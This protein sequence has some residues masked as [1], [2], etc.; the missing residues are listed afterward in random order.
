MR[1]PAP[2]ESTAATTGPAPS[3]RERATVV[4]GWVPGTVL[5]L[6]MA[7][8]ACLVYSWAAR[9]STPSAV[10]A[11]ATTTALVH[12]TVMVAIAAIIAI[13]YVSVGL[14]HRT[15][16]LRSLLLSYTAPLL[17]VLGVVSIV[18]LA[19]GSTGDAFR[20]AVEWQHAVGTTL[21]ARSAQTAWWSAALSLLALAALIPFGYRPIATTEFDPPPGRRPVLV[22]VVITLVLATAITTLTAL[23]TRP[24]EP[25]YP[26]SGEA[27]TTTE[28]PSTPAGLPT[29]EAFRIPFD[30]TD[31]ATA[32][33]VNL[34]ILAGAGIVTASTTYDG[35]AITGI[36]GRTGRNLWTLSGKGL[37]TESMY[38]T[39]VGTKSVVAVALTS[40]GSTENTLVGIDATTGTVLWS[41]PR[42]RL[43]KSYTVNQSRGALVV[44]VANP[45]PPGSVTS[46][47]L[48][49]RWI[50]LDPRTGKELWHRDFG[51]KCY[52]QG[53]VSDDAV[54]VA[55]CG[56]PRNGL[57]GTLL[58]VTSGREVRRLTATDLG[59]PPDQVASVVDVRGQYAVLEVGDDTVVANVVSGRVVKQFRGSGQLIDDHSVRIVS[60]RDDRISLADLAT[61]KQVTTRI[62]A[63]RD[64]SF[65][66]GGRWASVDGGWVGPGSAVA[67]TGDLGGDYAAAGNG[68]KGPD[69]RKTFSV[70]TSGQEVE[71]PVGCPPRTGLPSIYRIP[72]SAL[73]ICG[74]S[75]A[76]GLI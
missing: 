11:E 47:T 31:I 70:S 22:C 1:S 72:G 40:T 9:P 49:T 57:V 35:V 14:R 45:E 2:A 8:V 43:V 5:G 37:G 41:I 18:V 64:T 55:P 21:V 6:I 66:S 74:N 63:L 42:I 76:I 16:R 34:Q 17:A 20:T 52:A 51:Y 71:I 73:M 4:P 26:I 25:V 13:G 75:V 29:R 53:S 44:T 36:N 38:A 67:P 46:S 33:T 61:G 10:G 15:S 50:A 54:F 68:T 39:G 32:G 58:D 7:A 56:G 65:G 48:G 60:P 28:I 24:A 69:Q 62:F 30:S 19:H 3:S 23:S 59:L 27:A 12:T